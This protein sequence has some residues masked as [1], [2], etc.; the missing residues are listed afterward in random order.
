MPSEPV[1]QLPVAESGVDVLAH[2]IL[3]I[4]VGGLLLLAYKFGP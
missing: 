3:W 2:A 4:V 1:D